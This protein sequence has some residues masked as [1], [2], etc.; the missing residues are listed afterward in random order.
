MKSCQKIKYIIG[1]VAVCLLTMLCAVQAEA[2][3]SKTVQGTCD[4]DEAYQVLKLVNQERSRA[5]AESLIMDKELLDAAMMRA[6]EC[7]V[8]FSHT[9]PNGTDCFTASDKMFGENIALGYKSPAEVMKGWMNSEGHKKNIL[10]K[11]YHSIGIGCFVINGSKYWVQC[12][13]FAKAE[14]VSNPGKC[15]GTYKVSLSSSEETVLVRTGGED[16]D[17]LQSGISG[18]KVRAGKKKLTLTWKK[19]KGV[20]GYRIQISQNK[21]FKKPQSYIVKSGTTKKII[22]KFR[23]KRLTSRKKYYIR[24]CTYIEGTGENSKKRYGKWQSISRKVK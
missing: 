7:T 19:K 8:D 9:R 11:G 21:A 24:I 12:F 1:V 23:G 14:S 2:A 22:T 17:S 16:A 10:N 3:R 15:K 13:G 20:D 6:A 4:Y 18:F 5:G